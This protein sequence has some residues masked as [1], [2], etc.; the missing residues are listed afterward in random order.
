[1]GSRSK[2]EDIYMKIGLHYLS[3]QKNNTDNYDTILLI[4]NDVNDVIRVM[5]IWL[6]HPMCYRYST[7]ENYDTITLQEQYL[8]KKL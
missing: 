3:H 8:I 2:M 1:M 6:S 5:I 4:R 7:S